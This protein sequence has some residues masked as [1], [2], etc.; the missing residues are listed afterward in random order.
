[1]E[2]T[3]NE[4]DALKTH[5]ERMHKDAVYYGRFF[6]ERYAKSIATKLANAESSALLDEELSNLYTNFEEEYL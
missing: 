5:M 2:L 4:L 1:M 3:R 6:E